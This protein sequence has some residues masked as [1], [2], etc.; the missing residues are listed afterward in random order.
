MRFVL[1]LSAL[2]GCQPSDADL[3]AYLDRNGPMKTMSFGYAYDLEAP[4]GHNWLLG[5]A[6][7]ADVAFVNGG[8]SVMRDGLWR[9]C[10][11]VAVYRLMDAERGLRAPLQVFDSCEDAA[12]EPEGLNRY[13]SARNSLMLAGINVFLGEP[14]GYSFKGKLPFRPDIELRGNAVISATTVAL[15]SDNTVYIYELVDDAWVET[16]RLAYTGVPQLFADGYFLAAGSQIF[17]DED[18]EWVEVYDAGDRRVQ[19]LANGRALVSHERDHTWELVVWDG[20]TFTRSATVESDAMP[21]LSEAYVLSTDGSTLEVLDDEGTTLFAESVEVPGSFFDT[22]YPAFGTYQQALIANS[23]NDTVQWLQLLGYDPVDG[24]L[25][26]F[27]ARV[28]RG[29]WAHTSFE[30]PEGGNKLTVMMSGTG[31][32][33][34]YLKEGERPAL[35]DFDC[36]PY[37]AGS[38]EVCVVEN[39][40]PGTWYLGVNGF[41]AHSEVTV[42]ASID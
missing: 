28:A 16:S 37:R 14:V 5:H 20:T 6:G 41:E 10:P 12:L 32:A 35:R 17:R 38:D 27:D 11:S 18:G 4:E 42:T 2:V 33:D 8:Q 29:E 36:S 39:P 31:D 3:H 30:V 40:Q 15:L 7:D 13:I 23:A 22:M 1:A 21:G 26:S 25:A 19:G 9:E 24:Q 34:L